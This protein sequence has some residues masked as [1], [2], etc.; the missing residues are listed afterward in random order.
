M[1][2]LIYIDFANTEAGRISAQKFYAKVDAEVE[3]LMNQFNIPKEWKEES[4]EYLKES[5]FE[6]VKYEIHMNPNK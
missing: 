3:R 6:I 2:P 5:L 4:K 1:L